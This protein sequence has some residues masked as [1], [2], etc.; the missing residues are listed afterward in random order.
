M[1]RTCVIAIRGAVVV[2][3]DLGRSRQLTAARHRP[4]ATSPADDF[5]CIGWPDCKNHDRRDGDRRD[6][7]VRISKP[8]SGWHR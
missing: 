5:M 3:N 1:V 8:D 7:N 6:G 2:T 4:A